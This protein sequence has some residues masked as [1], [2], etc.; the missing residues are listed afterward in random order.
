MKIKTS[1]GCGTTGHATVNASKTVLFLPTAVAGA[2]ALAY[3]EGEKFALPKHRRIRNHDL[4]AFITC[5]S[6]IKTT[7][8]IHH[9]S[10]FMVERTV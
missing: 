2:V 5:N 7:S 9:V 10:D 8:T 4:S 3:S 6:I 1:G